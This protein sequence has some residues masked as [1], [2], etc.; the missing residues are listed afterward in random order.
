MAC[1]LR[2]S[3][4]VWVGVPE[5]FSGLSRH[6]GGPTLMDIWIS[7]FHR[8]CK[9]CYLDTSDSICGDFEATLQRSRCLEDIFRPFGM[10]P[11]VNQAL[12]RS[13]CG[14]HFS[15]GCRPSGGP[16]GLLHAPLALVI[17]RDCLNCSAQALQ[18]YSK[19]QQNLGTAFCPDERGSEQPKCVRL[20]PQVC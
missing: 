20:A 16:K 10:R 15:P 19:G 5:A 1:N 9:S 17:R 18:I 12:Q 11:K 14:P 2:L 3:S 7:E 6:T 8:W 4:A 13:L